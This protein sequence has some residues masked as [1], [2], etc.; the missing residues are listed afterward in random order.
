HLVPRARLPRSRRAQLRVNF[1]C[2]AG[3]DLRQRLHVRERGVEVHD[4]GAQRVAAADD[5]IRDKG[6]SS[7]LKSIEQL[8]IERIEMAF[9]LLA[10]DVRMHITRNVTECGDAQ[11]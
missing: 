4:T 11:F 2:D 5:R 3:N 6:L 1:L 10:S 9:D 7:P 8:A